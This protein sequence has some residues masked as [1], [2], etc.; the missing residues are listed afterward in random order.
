MKILML[1]D[2]VGSPGRQAVR[3]S[4]PILKE[5][6]S[7]DFVIANGENAAG[8]SGITPKIFNELISAGVDVLTSGDH[9]FKK[10]EIL[11]IIGYQDRLLRPANYPEGVPGRGYTVI[12]A[13]NNEK[14]GVIN[15]NGR[16]FMEALDCPFRRGLDI[17]KKIKEETQVVIVDM[18]AE[19]TSEKIAM[20]WHLNGKATAVLGTHTHVQTADE[21]VL[22]G[23]DY[24]AYITDIGMTGPIDSVIGRKIEHILIRFL[25]HTPTRFEVASENVQVQGV[26]IDLDT[27]SGKARTIKRIREKISDT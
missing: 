21:R 16:V 10:K 7:I 18:H 6:E 9:I 15:L 25:H 4:V 17:I 19:A 27:H 13:K 11:D 3:K 26:I 14:V 1:G 22:P 12:K 23:F 8:G 2:I 5:R 20:G 24:T